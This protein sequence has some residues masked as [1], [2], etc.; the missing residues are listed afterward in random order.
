MPDQPNPA[1]A[2]AESESK[3]ITQEKQPVG[4]HAH[5]RGDLWF[6]CPN[7]TERDERGTNLPTSC[8]WLRRAAPPAR[9]LL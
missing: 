7:G 8:A 3:G 9:C 6:L 4:D 5:R 1:A 2:R